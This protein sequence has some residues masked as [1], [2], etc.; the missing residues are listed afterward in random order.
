MSDD[1]R[2]VT[3]ANYREAT[4]DEWQEAFWRLY[5]KADRRLPLYEMMLQ[6][7]VDSSRLAEAMRKGRYVEAL[8]HIPRIFS[9]LCTLTAKCREEPDRYSDLVSERSHLSDMI[10]QKYPRVCALC[11][12]EKCICPALHVDSLSSKDRSAYTRTLETVLT[13]ARAHN[14]HPGSLDSWVDMFE[15]IYGAVNA[16]RS[17][18]E[19]TFHYLEEV[20]EVE[21]ELRKADRIKNNA[22]PAGQEDR[23]STIE[24]E[25]EIADVFSWLTAVFLHINN[26]WRRA[27]ELVAAFRDRVLVQAEVLSETPDFSPTL[28]EWLWHEFGSEEG[29][30]RC[31]RCRESSCRCKAGVRRR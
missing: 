9:W 6:V 24:F 4:L 13:R 20:G 31:H 2:S 23:Y 17:S 25:A 7:V 22:V 30:L 21:V 15:D 3:T 12:Q 14:E 19:K 8:P 10:W 26:S 27:D 5:C 28:S 18:A 16:T 11:A 1:Q 29:G